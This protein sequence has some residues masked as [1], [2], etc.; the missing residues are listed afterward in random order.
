MSHSKEFIVDVGRGTA[1]T[2]EFG[3][4]IGYAAGTQIARATVGNVETE[5]KIRGM[6]EWKG[7][8]NDREG[9]V[10]EREEEDEGP[11]EEKRSDIAEHAVAI[12]RV[13]LGHKEY[14]E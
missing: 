6:R 2:A 12:A 7:K 14:H 5:L 9:Q 1:N 11:L 3:A 4:F 8:E 10:D 13:S